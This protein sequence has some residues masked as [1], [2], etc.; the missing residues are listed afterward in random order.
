[1]NTFT[2]YFS[3]RV[4]RCTNCN[5]VI[6]LKQGKFCDKCKLKDIEKNNK[7]KGRKGTL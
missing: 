7:P 1:M 6:G 3:L 4:P 5:V 2:N